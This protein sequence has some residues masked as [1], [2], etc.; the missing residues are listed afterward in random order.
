MNIFKLWLQHK[1]GK[2]KKL[3]D[4]PEEF[5]PKVTNEVYFDYY[6]RKCGYQTSDFKKKC[7]KCGGSYVKTEHYS[8]K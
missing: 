2:G 6:C 3:P 4:I 5:L 1:K 7:I 8:K